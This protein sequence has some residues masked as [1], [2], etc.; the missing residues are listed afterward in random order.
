MLTKRQHEVLARLAKAYDEERYEDAEIV[1]EGIHVYAGTER[2]S[3]KTLEAFIDH[4]LVSLEDGND[5]S[6]FQRF[7]INETGLLVARKPEMAD[8]IWLALRKGKPFTFK[9]DQIVYLER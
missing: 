4:C 3:R 6:G 5:Q 2:S 8:P 1:A 7:S 9:D